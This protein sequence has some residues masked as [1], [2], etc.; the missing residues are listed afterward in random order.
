MSVASPLASVDW[1]TVAAAA[2]TFIAAIWLSIKGV[3][4]GKS[5]V[6]SGKS[7][8]TTI[9]GASIIENET[10]RQYTDQLRTNS[11]NV[12]EL[13]EQIRN[14]TAAITRQTDLD[15]VRRD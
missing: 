8:L 11:Q 2:G 13:C 1:P 6:E 4:K 12:H 5:R 9:V 7:E 15:L 10:L 3:Q 14:L